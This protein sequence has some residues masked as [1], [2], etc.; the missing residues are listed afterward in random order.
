M[1]TNATLD[2]A[3]D[4]AIPAGIGSFAQPMLLQ[5]VDLVPQDE[6]DALLD[7]WLASLAPREFELI[8]N[9]LAIDPMSGRYALEPT[10]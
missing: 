6:D 2:Q 9:D 1:Q 4:Y 8:L 5:A 10:A 3:T 7:S